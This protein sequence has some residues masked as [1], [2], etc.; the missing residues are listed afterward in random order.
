VAN[1]D[2]WR[3]DVADEIS[4]DFWR[5][6]RA[7]IKAEFPEALIVGEVWHHAPDFLQGDQWDSVMNYPFYRAVLDYAADGRMSAS[8]FLGAIGFQR[9]NT[10]NAAHHLMWNLIGSHDTARILH[11]C[12]EDK[13]RQ[14]LCAALQLL[15]PGMPM[16]YYG[17]EVAMSGAK[18]PDCRR[19][20]LW[21]ESRQD[22][23]MLRW[24]K[25]LLQLRRDIPAITRG[26]TLSEMTVDECGAIIITRRLADEEITLIFCS[27]ECELPLPRLCGKR[28]LITGNT[29]DGILR[30][31]VLVLR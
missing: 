26:Q 4:H 1:I 12:G 19:G 8:D 5:S 7:R 20:M 24:Y 31:G 22:K 21:D 13:P 3:L 25:R 27:K 23:D 11:L 14:R 15:L 9:G 2:G 28:D 6:F 18:D 29:F 17:D 30:G 10:H 16:I